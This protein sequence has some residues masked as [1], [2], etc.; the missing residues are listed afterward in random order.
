VFLWVFVL[1][2]TQLSTVNFPEVRRFL[3]CVL[4]I[5]RLQ[6]TSDLRGPKIS[7]L[8]FS[9]LAFSRS[10]FTQSTRSVDACPPINRRS[11][12]TSALRRFVA[13]VLTCHITAC[14]SI[15]GGT[16]RQFGVTRFS[17]A[18]LLMLTHNPLVKLWFGLWDCLGKLSPMHFGSP[19]CL[20]FVDLSLPQDLMMVTLTLASFTLD[21]P[22]SPVLRSNNP[23]SLMILQWRSLLNSKGDSHYPLNP[24]H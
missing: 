15:C 8:N 22:C 21:D 11:P 13:R 17:P 5:R 18:I 19:Q 20:L 1:Q 16:H 10:A 23:G 14:L 7:I 3:P 24:L 4:L 2:R 6:F 12:T 9:L